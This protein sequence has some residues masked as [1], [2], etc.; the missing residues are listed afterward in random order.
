M[1]PIAVVMRVCRVLKVKN[2]VTT[3]GTSFVF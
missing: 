1:C 2:K 3:K